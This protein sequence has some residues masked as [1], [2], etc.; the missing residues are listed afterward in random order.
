[1]RSLLQLVFFLGI[2]AS[3]GIGGLMLAC[4]MLGKRLPKFP[5]AMRVVLIV[6]AISIVLNIIGLEITGRGAFGRNVSLA[7]LP[8]D[9]AIAAYFFAGLVRAALGQ[10]LLISGIYNA[11]VFATSFLLAWTFG[12][13]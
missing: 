12:Q 4:K 9:V 5:A 13:F 6:F 11:V 3:A 10:A 8:V 7:L 2:V 1:M